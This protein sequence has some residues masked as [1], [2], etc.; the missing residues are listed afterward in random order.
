MWFYTLKIVKV[1]ALLPTAE[2]GLWNAWILIVPYMY[3]ALGLPFFL[4]IFQKRKATFW[5]L[6][7]YTRIE[8]VYLVFFYVLSI[9]MVF[10]SIFLP[11]ATDTIWF[12]AGLVVYLLGWVFLFSAWRTFA[13]TPVDKPNTTGIYRVSR[14]PWYVGMFF[15]YFGTGVATASWVFPLLAIIFSVPIRNALMI[16]EERECVERFGKAY[17]NY[18]DRTPRWIGKPKP[19]KSQNA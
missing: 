8:R 5:K 3:V 1:M 18:M 10:Y 6:P 7:S 19:N 15:V 17:R 4:G 12:Y 11:L 9:G 14:H 13:T 2:V 16:V